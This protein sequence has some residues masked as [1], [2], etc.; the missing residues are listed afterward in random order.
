MEATEEDSGIF[1]FK[2]SKAKVST[3]SIFVEG[4]SLGA[5]PNNTISKD[6]KEFYN[7]KWMKSF[8][9]RF[10]TPSMLHKPIIAV[11]CEQVLH[12]SEKFPPSKN[13]EI[14]EESSLS[15]VRKV[16]RGNRRHKIKT[17]RQ[18]N[19]KKNLK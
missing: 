18:R 14:V 16:T 4:T 9:K 10:L 8:L 11:S 3:D 6:A 2:N 12:E 19:L 1:L 13:D 17:R 7:G 5:N 15:K